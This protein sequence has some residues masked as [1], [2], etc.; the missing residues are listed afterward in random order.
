MLVAVLVLGSCGG[1]DKASLKLDGSPR[2]PDAEGVV[3]R[4]DFESLELEDG[5]QFSIDRDLQSFSTYTL[6]PLALLGR[7]GQYVQLGLDGKNIRWIASIGAVLRDTKASV[8]YTGHLLRVDGERLIFRDGTTFLSK[9]PVEPG[10]RGAFVIVE[11]DP[12]KGKV[13]SLA[14]S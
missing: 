10:L 11:I 8:F 4:V 14:R 6:E 13:R 2:I 9:V 1:D 7:D 12:E 3:R 5:R